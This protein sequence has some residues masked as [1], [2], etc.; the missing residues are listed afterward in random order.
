MHHFTYSL[1]YN[2]FTNV[3]RFF[4]TRIL[5]SFTFCSAGLPRRHPRGSEHGYKSLIPASRMAFFTARCIR[6]SSTCQR[7]SWP[8]NSFFQ[9]FF[10]GKSHCHLSSCC[11]KDILSQGHW[12]GL[13]LRILLV[14]FSDFL[15]L[16]FQV[17]L[18][19][20]YVFDSERFSWNLFLNCDSAFA[21]LF[22]TG[23]LFFF[24]Q[25]RLFFLKKQ[26]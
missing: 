24:S 17:L 4:R 11:L 20:L 3:S 10:C 5:V 8:V 21:F 18:D 7:P 2:T 12:E 26:P 19:R 1:L 15:N 6:D 13:R 22:W 25:E 9:R 14:N 16:F 23:T